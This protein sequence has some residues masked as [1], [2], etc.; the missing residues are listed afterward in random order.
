[1]TDNPYGLEYDP[2]YAQ[3]LENLPEAEK[4]AKRYGDWN[5]FKGS[6]FTTFRPIRFPGEPSNALHVIKPFFIPE[7]WLR[8]LSIDWGKRAMCYAM[9]GAISPDRRVYV[10]RERAWKGKDI[11]HW[12]SEIRLVHDENSEAMEAVTLCG[13]A[14]QDRGGATVVDQFNDHSGLSASSSENTPGSRI[15]GLQLVHDFLRF[16]PRVTLRSRGEVFDFELAQKLYRLRGPEAY[17][18]YKREFIDESQEDNLPILQIFETCPIL[19]ETIPVAMYSETKQEDIEEFDGDDPL[20]DL[21]YF[22]K[23]AKR[24]INGE[25]GNLDQSQKIDQIVRELKM[26]GDMTKFYRRM[27]KAEDASNE[28]ESFRP[29]YRRG[30]M[31]RRRSRHVSLY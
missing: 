16:E 14:W 28:A 15:A 2:M 25:I 19:I 13:S 1:L 24:L 22:C 6:V 12:A 10:Y 4:R 29:L 5:A 18:S 26:Y 27:E 7:Y 21:R 8:I 20:D 30:S 23:T 17:E 11:A 9:W 31:S 3:K